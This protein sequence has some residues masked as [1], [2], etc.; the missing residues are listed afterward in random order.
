MNQINPPE[1]IKRIEKALNYIESR[2]K[3]SISLESMAESCCL[4]PYHFH[5]LFKML[6]GEPP[7]SYIRKRRLF[8][9]ALKIRSEN[10]KVID[11]AMEYGY[12]S[13]DAFSRAFT[14]QFGFN[15][16]EYKS[17]PAL[18]IPNEK[19]GLSAESLEHLRSNLNMTPEM[20]KRE[21]FHLIGAVYYGKNE[22]GEIPRLWQDQFDPL[23]DL[24][25]R[26][27]KSRAYGFCFHTKEYIEE[28]LFYYMAAVEVKDLS[29]VPVEYVGK[30][31]P[32]A[33]YAVFTHKGSPE[34]LG[35]TYEYIYGTWF[36]RKEY[37]KDERFDFELYEQD[38]SGNSVIRLFIPVI[39]L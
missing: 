29:C 10:Y 18:L 20:V 28:G 8:Q 35:T 22:N 32:A 9:A 19:P 14:R 27:N 3:E 23:T 4:S 13:S 5:K 30:T 11:A 26:I 6:T 34:S 16:K 2:L 39:R 37:Q 31:V 36:P 21:S 7:G 17:N 12:G 38:D 24:P 15:P 1:N 33:E 25:C